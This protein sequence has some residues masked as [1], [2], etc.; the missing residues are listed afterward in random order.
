VLQHLTDPVGALTE[1]RRVL[2]PGGILAVRDSDYAAFAWAPGDALLDRWLELYDGVCR[3]NGAEPNAGRYLLGWARSTGF[4][5]IAASSSTWTFADPD[6]REW[7]GEL[8]AERVQRS[9]LAKQALDYGLSTPDE[10]AAIADAWRRWSVQADGY[11]A[12]L[13]G[14]L[15]ARR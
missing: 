10:L 11:F 15:L 13:H 2:K 4:T 5:A 9:S 1:M 8:W 7:W 6:S 12:V 14:E 3:R